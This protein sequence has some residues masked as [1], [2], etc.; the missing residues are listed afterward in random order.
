MNPRAFPDV[1]RLYTDEQIAT[2]QVALVVDVLVRRDARY[3][4]VVPNKVFRKRGAAA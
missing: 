4:E 3:E 2:R 1:E